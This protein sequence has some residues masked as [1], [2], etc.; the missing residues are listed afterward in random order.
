MVDLRHHPD[1]GLRANGVLHVFDSPGERGSAVL[2]R[3]KLPAP[4]PGQLALYGVAAEDLPCP[5]I[6]MQ[7]GGDALQAWGREVNWETADPRSDA[8]Q[9]LLRYEGKW[10]STH[11]GRNSHGGSVYAQLG[12]WP[13]TWPDESAQEQLR[14]Q[15]VL[16]TYENSEPWLE[17]FRRGK[18]YDVRLRIT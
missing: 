18:G 12:G 8:I 7:K 4:Q 17:V 5:E 2:K 6:V 15:L 10:E 3:G 1:E 16:R 13:I 11:P 14:R 9:P